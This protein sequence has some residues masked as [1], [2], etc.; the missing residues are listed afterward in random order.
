[1]ILN[2]SVPLNGVF[3]E[4]LLPSVTMAEDKKDDKKG[5]KKERPKEST[6]ADE[7]RVKPSVSK[8][9]IIILFLLRTQLK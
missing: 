6:P 3:S 8:K 2:M 9:V 4:T 5:D 1:M 7:Q